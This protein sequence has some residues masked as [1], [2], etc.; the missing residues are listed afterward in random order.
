MTIDLFGNLNDDLFI[1]AIPRKKIYIACTYCTN[2]CKSKCLLFV[3][4][5]CVQL[6]VQV[7]Y[8]DKDQRQLT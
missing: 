1:T 5:L 4:P 6:Q 2:D 8:N 3:E 7:A